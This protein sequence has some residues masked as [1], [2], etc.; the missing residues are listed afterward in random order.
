[1]RV[2]DAAALIGAEIRGSAGATLLGAEVDSRRGT[3]AMT[4]CPRH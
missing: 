1:M 4:L 3:T 2:E